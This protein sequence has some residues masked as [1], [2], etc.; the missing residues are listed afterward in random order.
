MLKSGKLFSI[1]VFGF[2]FLV[3]FYVRC[4]FGV[5][6]SLTPVEPIA[7]A[8]NGKAYAGSHTCISCH[9]AIYNDH[10]KTPHYN[11]SQLASKGNIIG[12]FGTDA[13]VKLNDHSSVKMSDE[14]GLYQSGFEGDSLIGK[15]TFDITIGSGTKGQSY[16]YWKSSQLYQLPISY[17][18]ASENWILSPG[19]ANDHINFNRAVL[20]SCL[21]C[22][23][24]FARN[25]L[26][27][28]YT[29]NRFVK[30]SI[31]FGVACESCHG[32]SLQHVNAHITQPDLKIPQHILDIKLLSQQQQLDACA[33]CH[34]GSVRPNRPPFTFQTGDRFTDYWRP[35]AIVATDTD[36]LD[37]HGNQ[38]GLLTASTCFK[39]S[40]AMT[41]S[42][43]HNP[44]KN[45]R[46]AFIEFSQKC[47][48]CHNDSSQHSF[49]LNAQM[50]T[51]C[52]NCHM[53]VLSSSGL[54]VEALD[55]KGKILSDSLKV[56]T[57]R[58]GIY[59]NISER[60]YESMSN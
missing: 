12:G 22:H 23:T 50:Q 17:W 40:E 32:P 16:L 27:N 15:E 52:I 38:Y 49:A 25:H 51:N 30:T 56:R 43:C 60:V 46:G 47:M 44:H 36:T 8:Y 4:D 48:G 14:D 19:Y 41:C 11:T 29:S 45:Q 7:K 59:R 20:P 37:V 3:L 24:T 1:Y 39:A 34:S 10:L 42:T 31:L 6:H 33:K 53:P 54:T 55:L 35:N 28:D 13:I 21:E 18:N 2:L 57:H 9:E 58:I 5:T 26:P